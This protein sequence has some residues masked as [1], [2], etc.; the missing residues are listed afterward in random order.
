MRNFINKLN[1]KPYKVIIFIILISSF[2]LYLSYTHPRSIYYD[3]K[4]MAFENGITGTA[5]PIVIEVNGKYT[6]SILGKADEFSGEIKVGNKVFNF[7]DGKLSFNQDKIG[8]LFWDPTDGNA[9]SL[10]YVSPMLK[11]ITIQTKNKYIAAPCRHRTEAVKITNTLLKNSGNS[12]IV[13]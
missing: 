12:W 4:G 9:Y 10:I 3:Y 13:K 1:L 7:T 2:W 11:E 8:L 6:N 5:S